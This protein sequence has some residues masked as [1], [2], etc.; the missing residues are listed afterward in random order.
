[1]C[2]F[3]DRIICL[4]CTSA[5]GVLIR[6]SRI[7][8]TYIRCVV[9][10]AVKKTHLEVWI[11]GNAACDARLR[12]KSRRGTFFRTFWIYTG[13]PHSSAV[14]HHRTRLGRV[15]LAR[16]EHAFRMTH[17]A[18]THVPAAIHVGIVLCVD[19]TYITTRLFSQC[20][21]FL[22]KQLEKI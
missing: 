13:F 19:L 12:D 17:V 6:L 4:P 2:C 11:M 7:D 22:K 21:G 14:W 9:I 16:I 20:Y 10:Y 3:K 1:M 18:L 5:W 8:C 15:E